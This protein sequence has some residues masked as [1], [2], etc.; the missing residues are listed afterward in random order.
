[1]KTYNA[2]HYLLSAVAIGMV[3]T[4]ITGCDD[5]S[6]TSPVSKHEPSAVLKS[7]PQPITGAF[8]LEGVL[9][10]PG[11]VFNSFASIKGQVMYSLMS[12]PY[13]GAYRI[14]LD[15]STDATLMPD[16]GTTM[17]G[18]ADISHDQL[19][20]SEEGFAILEK[21]YTVVGTRDGMTLHLRFLLTSDGIELS[22]MWLEDRNF[23]FPEDKTD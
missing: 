7:K 15:L 14:D 17:W 16:G 1:M 21:S 22:R 9:R 13:R 5:S 2:V 12:M 3:F 8:P 6:V 4:A 19:F 18:A 10:V 23:R 20:V 11:R